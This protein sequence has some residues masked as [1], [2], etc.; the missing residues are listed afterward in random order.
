MYIQHVAHSACLVAVMRCE[1]SGGDESKNDESGSCLTVVHA[2]GRVSSRELPPAY[3]YHE[4][5]VV[6]ADVF[7]CACPWD[8]VANHAAH[9][10]VVCVYGREL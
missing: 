2:D 10:E 5:W 9:T 3:W 7:A 8:Q 1:D 4:M 6:G